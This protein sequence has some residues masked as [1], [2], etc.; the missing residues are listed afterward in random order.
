[1]YPSV[2]KARY[3]FIFQLDF[4]MLIVVLLKRPAGVVTC[5]SKV[6]SVFLLLI[7]LC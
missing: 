7:F 1:M 5:L 6:L 3:L 4:V 2:V